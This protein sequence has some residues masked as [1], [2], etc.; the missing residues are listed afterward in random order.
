MAAGMFTAL[1]I[2]TTK[3]Y[4]EKSV[5]VLMLV[6][7]VLGPG[8]KNEMQDFPKMPREIGLLISIFFRSLL[9]LLGTNLP[10]PAGIFMPVFLIGGM[11]G[12]FVGHIMV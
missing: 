3:A 7:D 8:K 6:S 12:R 2:Y 4:S 10:V 1:I 11:F 9:T 5:G